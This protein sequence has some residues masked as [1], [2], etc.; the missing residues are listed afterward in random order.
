MGLFK[1]LL[2]SAAAYGVYKFL[3]EQD[4]IGRSRLDEIKE[5]VPHLVEEA[6]TIKDGLQG[7]YVPEADPLNPLIHQNPL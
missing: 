3:T 2:Y 1:T 4:A 7:G 5:Q 6:K